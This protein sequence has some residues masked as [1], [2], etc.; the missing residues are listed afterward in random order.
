MKVIAR[1]FRVVTLTLLAVLG[2]SVLMYTA[3]GYFSD[4]GE[5]DAQHAATTRATLEAMHQQQTSLGVLLRTEIFG[6]LHGDAGR[7]RQYDVPVTDLLRE[8]WLTSA[9]L[10]AS[11]LILGWSAALIV[12]VP[13]SLV[14]NPGLDVAVAAST[15]LLLAAPVGALATLCLVTDVGGPA[16]VLGLLVA[17]RDFKLLH[18][19]LRGLWSAPYLLH[20]RAQGFSLSRILLS[21]VPFSLRSDLISLLTLSFTLCLSALV[22][23]EVVFDRAGLGQLAWAAAMNRDLPVLVAVTA[24]I[25]ACIGAAGALQAAPARTGSDL[26]A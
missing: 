18:R 26:C 16:M 20:A 22:P 24:L 10:L 23:V 1:L 14:R 12:A 25:A 15:A 17:V 21:H 2:T 8:R 5:L 9:K 6:W 19:V 7:S 4:S 11:G 13:L 3:P